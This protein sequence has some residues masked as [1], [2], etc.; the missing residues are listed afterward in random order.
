MAKN[1][2]ICRQN[3]VQEVLTHSH[4][5]YEAILKFAISARQLRDT[6]NKININLL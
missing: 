3:G 5:S 4:H 6:D 2:N 1:L